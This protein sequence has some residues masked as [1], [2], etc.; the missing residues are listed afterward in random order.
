MTAPSSC[1]L[2]LRFLVETSGPVLLAEEASLLQKLKPAGIMLRRRNIVQGVPYEEWLGVYQRY[3]HDVR[4]AIGRERIVVSVDHEGGQVHRFPAPITRFPY[5][6]YYGLD[7]QAVEAVTRSMAEELRSLGVNVSF[8]PV[9]DIHSNPQN[10]V[11]HQ[12]AFGRS[13][14]VVSAAASVC[15]QTLAK[16]GV[17]PC[18][19]HFPG[20][21]DTASDSHTELPLVG[22]TLDE[23]RQRELV[24][25]KALINQGIPMVMSGHIL[26]PAIDPD[27]PATISSRLMRD[28]LRSELGFRGVSIA[29]ALGMKGITAQRL[30]A[31]LFV[32]CADAAQLDIFLFVGDTVT[33]HDALAVYEALQRYTM[34]SDSALSSCRVSEER[35]TR[36]LADALQYEVVRLP[37]TV[38][39]AHAHLATVLG[40]NPPW[41]AFNFEPEGFV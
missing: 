38:F 28:L 31:D 3:L 13:S 12:R 30:D 11:I 20:H 24:P 7:L 36:L 25:F 18:A 37:D 8:S 9:A 34:Q 29:D 1:D 10:P 17:I 6:A 21:G 4:T 35:I 2:G 26:V 15:A 27:L 14:E 41:E 22:R 33:L 40:Q 5:P 23:L 19:K 16:N 39:E 32:Q